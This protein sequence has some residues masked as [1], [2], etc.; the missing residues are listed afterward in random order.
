MQK[1]LAVISTNKTNR[2]KV[3]ELTVERFP[4]QVSVTTNL[5]NEVTGV[6]ITVNDRGLK[7]LRSVL[8]VNITPAPPISAVEIEEQS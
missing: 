3:L 6:L 1:Y 2:G 8:E 4:N 7:L 5:L